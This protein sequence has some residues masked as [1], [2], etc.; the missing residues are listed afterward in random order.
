[1]NKQLEMYLQLQQ[2]QQQ[3]YLQ[4]QQYTQD[5]PAPGYVVQMATA[6]DPGRDNSKDLTPQQ[7]GIQAMKRVIPVISAYTRL[8]LISRQRRYKTLGQ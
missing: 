8:P 7:L 4:R 3:Q 5:H 2:L 6:A 1:M